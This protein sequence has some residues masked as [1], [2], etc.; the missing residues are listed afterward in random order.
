MSSFVLKKWRRAVATLLLAPVMAAVL[1]TAT[2]IAEP[3]RRA[4]VVGINDYANLPKLIKAVADANALASTLKDLGFEP[5]TPVLDKEADRLAFYRAWGNF[6]ST[7]NEGDTVVVYFS[8]HGLQVRGIN[9]LLPAD[10]PGAVQ[11][12][13]VVRAWS[14]NF[15][16]LSEALERKKPKIALYILDA[17]RDNPFPTADGK[18]SFGGQSGLAALR[19]AQGEVISG[20]FVMYSAGANEQALDW[21]TVQ[22]Q[23]PNSVYTRR[24]L[25]LL[26]TPNLSLLDIAKRVQ[27]EVADDARN[28]HFIDG[29]HM[30]HTQRPAYYDGI[31]GQFYLAGN[32]GA[33]VSVATAGPS[34]STPASTAAREWQDVKGSKNIAALQAFRERHSGDAVYASLAD[35]SIA[36]LQ[37]GALASASASTTAPKRELA[38]L[39]TLANPRDRLGALVPGS[40]QEA[41]DCYDVDPVRNLACPEMVVLPAGSF[42]MGSPDNESGRDTDEGPLRTV[43]IAQPFAVGKFEV[44]FDEWDACV[45]GGGCTH[46]PSDSGWG[47]GRRPVINVSWSDAKEY[48]AWLSKLTGQPY[49]LLTEAEWEYAARAVTSTAMRHTVYSFGD[50]PG[51]LGEHAWYYVNAGDRTNPVGGKKA[52]AFGLHDM[53]GNISEW[54]EDCNVD[55]YKAA[56]SDGSA[57]PDKPGCSRLF[58]GGSWLNRPR[59][60]RIAHRNRD[61]LNSRTN[62]YGFRIARSFVFAKTP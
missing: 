37:R 36:A 51:P 19:S 14:V 38:P 31:E 3:K 15:N 56:P 61:N 12:E 11:G 6:L 1:F 28:R 52:N 2:A 27:G 48:V 39:P 55:S 23:S 13:E 54:V 18:K 22:D 35:Q 46:N 5:T 41:R 20:A 8:G 25:P 47:K 45:A 30:R 24:L 34:I 9:Y 58:R 17:C 7:V 21:L 59:F 29:K 44:T 33:P 32:A 40:G 43:T 26:K 16:D 62:K 60:L 53:L 10:V 4:F 49:R 42:T 57:V 50:D